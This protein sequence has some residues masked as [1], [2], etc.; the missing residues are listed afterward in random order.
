MSESFLSEELAE[1]VRSGKPARTRLRVTDGTASFPVLRS[2][3]TGFA[4]A[5]DGAPR[6]R[7]LVELH[8]GARHLSTCLIV[9]SSEDGGEMIYEFKRNTAAEAGPA[10][11]F[12]RDEDAPVAL[13]GPAER[14]A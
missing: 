12:A 4:L 5:L 10:L 13:I 6:L 14:P 1:A 9:A 7:G 8:D 11:D 3:S 2:W